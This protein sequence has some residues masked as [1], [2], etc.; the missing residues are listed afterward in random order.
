MKRTEYLIS[1]LLMIT[2]YFIGSINSTRNQPE[3]PPME[4]ESF[5]ISLSVNDIQVSYDFYA[6]LGYEVIDGQGSIADKWI[7]LQNGESRI[8]LFEGFFPQNT[9]TFNPIDGRKLYEKLENSGI[10]G[11]KIAGFDRDS[12]PCTFTLLDPDQ[13]PILFDQHH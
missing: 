1:A 11:M 5:S 12:G 2:F 7:L 6:K 10:D 3:I 13:N 8:G 9:I 4:L